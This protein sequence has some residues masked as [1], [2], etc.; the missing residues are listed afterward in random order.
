MKKLLHIL[1]LLPFL[2]N[3]QIY[4]NGIKVGAPI[5]RNAS[6]DAYP[7]GYSVLLNGGRHSYATLA[8]RDSLNTYYPQLLRDGMEVY[9]RAT[10]LTYRWN[11]STSAWNTVSYGLTYTNG[12]GLGL[13][14]TQFFVD[15]TLIRTTANSLSLAQLQTKFGLE[16]L[17]AVTNRGNATTLRI[18]ALGFDVTGTGGNGY[19]FFPSQS[20][21]PATPTGGFNLFADATGRFSWKSPLGFTRTLGSPALTADRVY[22]FVDASYTVPGLELANIFTAD[23]TISKTLPKF[24]LTTTGGSGGMQLDALLNNFTIFN[25]NKPAGNAG[26]ALNL[27]ASST[28]YASASDALFPSGASPF[29]VDYWYRYTGSGT[30][31]VMVK[32]GSVAKSAGISIVG[33]N[34]RFGAIN[35]VGGNVS[36]NIA[37]DIVTDQQWHHIDVTY[38]GTIIRTYLDGV[39][40]ATQT[41]TLDIGNG[42][43][44]F[45][46]RDLTPGL[47]CS[48]SFDQVKFGNAN[49]SAANVAVNYNSGL[50][51]NPPY[52][53]NL[54]VRYEL[55]ETS[56]TT[57]ADLSGNAVTL[58]L[59][60]TAGNT[61]DNSG[62]V[63]SASA[64]TVISNTIDQVTDGQSYGEANVITR[65]V[66]SSQVVLKGQ[67]L[68]A[69]IGGYKPWQIGADGN[70][71]LRYHGVNF[72]DVNKSVN[73]Y[74]LFL[75]DPNGSTLPPLQFKNQAAITPTTNN[76]YSLYVS[77]ANTRLRYLDG[78]TENQLA[79]LSDVTAGVPTTRTITIDGV[80]QDLSANR[81]YTTNVGDA[82]T[83]TTSQDVTG[84]K[85]WKAPAFFTSSVEIRNAVTTS[86]AWTLRVDSNATG[87]VSLR[88]PSTFTTGTRAYVLPVNGN[89][90]DTLAL[91]SYYYDKLNKVN[92]QTIT[93]TLNVSGNI[94]GINIIGSGGL[95]GAYAQVRNG[96]TGLGGVQLRTTSPNSNSI[97]QKTL[98]QNTD[99]LAG[100]RQVNQLRVNATPKTAS[101]S[102]TVYDRIVQYDCTS[103]NIPF[104]LPALTD[105]FDSELS[106]G[107]YFTVV[108]TDAS[109]NTIQ[110]SI[111][112]GGNIWDPNTKTTSTTYNVLN[113]A[114]FYCD[115]T[116]YTLVKGND[117]MY[118]TPY[119]VSAN[120]TMLLNGDYIN[121]SATQ[122]NLTLPPC[123]GF[124]SDGTKIITIL[125]T[126][127]GGAKIVVPSG[128]SMQS[129]TTFATTAGTG[130]ATLTQGQKV[131]LIPTGTNSYY[132]QP[133]NGT[134][135]V[136]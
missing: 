114:M 127:T 12:Y 56:G 79:Y 58:N 103:G 18:S 61:V 72:M 123:N 9:V 76:A 59:F 50:G 135:T 83:R 116:R 47:Y 19:S 4:T 57:R 37:G 95:F 102:A 36:V 112:S 33:G 120:A 92:P 122:Y 24:S 88:V 134:I 43:G 73:P 62:R 64:G 101:Y 113:S 1:F 93:G 45:I 54:V 75:I 48:G 17:Q 27:L 68:N 126:G 107:S 63:P 49:I 44:F 85:R 15:T 67:Y 77:T 86:G 22:N 109:A 100:F 118:R 28:Q 26:R 55:D 65:G 40:K 132:L 87:T 82:V 108:K 91:T 11:N 25:G 78:T 89:A 52:T 125:V 96:N 14:G 71:L 74:S 41:V 94:N 110:V 90:N 130:G 10:D 117:P 32:W 97:Y 13:T 119:N 69:D 46:G 51:T 111:S 84:S 21:M 70:M 81:T 7:T 129:G 2:A 6:G 53:G 20:T 80:T 124:T 30:Q 5:I 106:R 3:A 60:N 34:A 66:G 99:T 35:S 38:D 16:N 121:T 23:Q 105:G 131:Q 115:G 104:S 29:Y 128:Y 31:G 42:A 133:L 39:A 136:Y 8:G 98:T